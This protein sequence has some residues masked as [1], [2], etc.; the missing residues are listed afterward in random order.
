MNDSLLID[1]AEQTANAGVVK[2]LSGLY[3]DAIQNYLI[4]LRI[5]DSLNLDLERS[6][7]LNNIGIVY[8]QINENEKALDYYNSLEISKKLNRDDINAIRYN[9]IATVYEEED[10][11]IDSALYYYQKSYEIWKDDT[12]K[13]R[14]SV[15]LNNMGYVYL[16]KGNYSKADSLFSIALGY[17]MNEN[18]IENISLVYRN[19]ALL[20]LKIKEYNSAIDKIKQAISL[21]QDISNKENEQK[22][23]EILAQ[24]FELNNNF[25][26]ANNTLK[27]YYKN[28][29]VLN[30]IEQ[31]KNINALNIKYEVKDKE[32]KILILEIKNNAKSR[33]VWLLL[34]LIF[35]LVLIISALVY[36]YNLYKKNS[37]LELQQ[38][39]R[40]IFDYI[41]QIE[42]IKEQ[43]N[44]NNE[45][46]EKT[47]LEKIKQYD[48]TQTEEKVLIL[49]TE[50]NKNAEIAEKLFISI[51]TVKTHTRNIFIKLDVRNRVEATQKAQK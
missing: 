4:S 10:Y 29:E 20:L 50:G 38:M 37:K 7:I 39:R 43:V 35:A 26:N 3:T 33:E 21:S 32:Q 9:N 36:V 47:I 45:L 23:R 31:K 8:Q 16:V 46:K 1:Y 19:Q 17:S 27:L 22:C 34:G 42:E 12:L 18:Q 11:N 49:I 15:L 2:E 48:L 41:S 28:Q 25:K 14:L 44:K 6:K 13:A 30:G 51:N 40:D 24:A 5:F